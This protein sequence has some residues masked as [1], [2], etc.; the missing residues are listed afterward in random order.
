M[1]CLLSLFVL[2]FGS[3]SRSNDRVH[4]FKFTFLKDQISVLPLFQCQKSVVLYIFVQFFS[5]YCGKASLLLII[6]S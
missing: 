1:L 4:F 2:W 6:L 5:V 3:V